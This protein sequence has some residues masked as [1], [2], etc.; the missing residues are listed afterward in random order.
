MTTYSLNSKSFK[1]NSIYT[2]EQVKAYLLS[3]P[4]LEARVSSVSS[5]GLVKL[6]FSKKIK[7]PE[8]WQNLGEKQYVETIDLFLDFRITTESEAY[9]NQ[10]EISMVN[11]TRFTDFELDIQLKFANPTFIGTDNY[12]PDMLEI[13]IK[14]LPK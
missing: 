9:A 2:L 14:D 1:S 13:R 5:T 4:P 12:L 3:H 6:A 11:V 7:V 8:M 10:K